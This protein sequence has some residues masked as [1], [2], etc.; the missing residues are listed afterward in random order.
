[1]LTE[2]EYKHTAEVVKSFEQGVGREL[3]KKYLERTKGMRNWVSNDYTYIII[4]QFLFFFQLI[5]HVEAWTKG[6]PLW[7]QHFH[8]SWIKVIEWKR[9]WDLFQ[10]MQLTTQHVTIDSDSESAAVILTSFR[11]FWFW[12]Q[13]PVSLTVFPSQFKF[14]GNFVSLSSRS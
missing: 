11:I 6:L 12:D 5:E 13:G 3:Q 4:F 9:H 10:K 7:R 1:M 2:E 8:I 14:D